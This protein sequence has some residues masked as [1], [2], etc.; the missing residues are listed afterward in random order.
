MNLREIITHIDTN[1]VA[2]T[3]MIYDIWVFIHICTYLC[4]YID[5]AV[6]TDYEHI[7]F[8]GTVL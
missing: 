2:I 7:Q 4:M 6:D 5:S 8:V 3:F 1:L